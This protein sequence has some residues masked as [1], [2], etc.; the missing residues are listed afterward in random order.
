[1]KYTGQDAAPT[2]RTPVSHFLFVP[3]FLAT[4]FFGI[5]IARAGEVNIVAF[6]GLYNALGAN[7]AVKDTP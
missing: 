4:L 2:R 5:S 7:A 6:G 1:M 3:L